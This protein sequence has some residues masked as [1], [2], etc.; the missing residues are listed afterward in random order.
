MIPEKKTNLIINTNQLMFIKEN[1]PT[2]VWEITG[3]LKRIHMTNYRQHKLTEMV[4]KLHINLS[5]SWNPKFHFVQHN[6][7]DILNTCK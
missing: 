1:L 4:K 2:T 7:I 5:Y 6:I 3:D